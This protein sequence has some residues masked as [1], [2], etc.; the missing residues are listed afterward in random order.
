MATPPPCPR[1]ALVQGTPPVQTAL[2]FAPPTQVCIE[3]TPIVQGTPPVRT[4]FF[5]SPGRTLDRGSRSWYAEN[6]WWFMLFFFLLRFA[7]FVM[8]AMRTCEPGCCMIC[9]FWPNERAWT[10]RHPRLRSAFVQRSCKGNVA[11]CYQGMKKFHPIKSLKF[12]QGFP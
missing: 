1:H 10:P 11:I 2:F 6:T 5:F 8:F 3:F 12:C 7:C 4:A 9:P